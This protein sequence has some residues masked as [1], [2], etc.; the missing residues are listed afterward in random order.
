M[1]SLAENIVV[2]YLTR[3]GKVFVVPQYAIPAPG[4]TGDW[5][6][7]DILALDFGTEEV[8]VVEVATGSRFAGL[9]ARVAERETR[10]FA[11]IRAKL[12]ADGLAIQV[13]W[14]IR[15]FG[16]VREDCL[17]D[18]RRP[19]AGHGDVAFAAI[20]GATFPW[21]YWDDRAEGGLPR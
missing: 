8:V 6:C 19:F 2:T 1:E 18:A 14:R 3:G 15:F 17:D 11:P 5:A 13:G 10:W 9:L 16:F 4:A 21:A 7:P 20:E 12:A